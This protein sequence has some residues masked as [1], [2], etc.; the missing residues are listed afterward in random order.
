MAEEAPPP[1][2]EIEDRL[3][4]L[5]EALREAGDD[6][7]AEML[8]RHADGFTDRAAVRREVNAIR[9]HL[10]RWRD[11]PEEL[12]ESAK[13]QLA[14]NR[15]EDVCIEAL[16]S[17]VI[18]AAPL[19]LGEHSRRKLGIIFGT[20]LI[21]SVIMLI[22]ILLV[23]A[24]I[25]FDDLGE[26]RE[27]PPVEL[28]RGEE[29][30]LEVSALRPAKLPGVTEGVEVEIAGGCQGPLGNGTCTEA[31]PRLWPN[32]RLPTYELKLRNQAYGLL[33]SLGEGR[34]RGDVGQG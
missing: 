28:P 12:V 13:V 9:Q 1:I 24:G 31:P 6:E 4:D 7:T 10:V 22:P 34:M 20:L 14:A 16:G 23:E 17:G 11:H 3:E 15:L 30:V 26:V 25:D 21:G 33:F 27:L 18:E 2:E 19:S 8:E 29:A 5:T 32:G